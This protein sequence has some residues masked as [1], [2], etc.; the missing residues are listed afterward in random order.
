MNI[1]KFSIVMIALAGSSAC[2]NAPSESD[3]KNIVLSMLGDCRYLSLERFEKTN[4]IAVGNQGYKIDLAYTVKVTALPESKQLVEENSQKLAEIDSRLEKA[5]AKSAWAYAER[6]AYQPKIDKA[7]EDKNRALEDAL[8]AEATKFSYEQFNPSLDAVNSLKKERLAILEG[9]VNPL[10]ARFI[11][12]CPKVNFFLYERLFEDADA[13]QYA[14]DFTK[15]FS[16][17]IP[18]I[19]TDNGWMAAK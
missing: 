13:T 12:A 15:D 1:V 18:M 6:D 14:K 3:V 10:K 11:E 2:S 16:G 5:K 9:V 4:G 19:K 7:N 17:T 8:R